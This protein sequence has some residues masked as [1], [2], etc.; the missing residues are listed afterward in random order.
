MT[1]VIDQDLT[2]VK[3]DALWQR[4][5]TAGFKEQSEIMNSWNLI[6][7]N[8]GINSLNVTKKQAMVVVE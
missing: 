2:S 4:D 6:I 7:K 8:S 5:L 1:A 3:C